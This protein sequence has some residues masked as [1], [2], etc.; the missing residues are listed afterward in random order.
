MVSS[1][2]GPGRWFESFFASFGR[3]VFSVSAF[4]LFGQF[5]ADIS[6]GYE[7]DRTVGLNPTWSAIL[8]CLISLCFLLPPHVG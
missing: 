3:Q 2:Q 5:S 7:C 4:P 8:K 6:E 1:C